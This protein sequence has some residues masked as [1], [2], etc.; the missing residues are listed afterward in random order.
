MIIVQLILS[1]S[2]FVTGT[3][4][5]QTVPG[6]VNKEIIL[7]LINEARKNGCTCG[8]T[9]YPPAAPLKWNDQL[10][11]AA[12]S[13]SNDMSKKNYFS[14][15][16]PSGTDAGSR[17]EKA[18]YAWT[19]YAENIGMGYR[20]EQEVVDAWLH[21]PGHCK[22]IM[23]Q[24]YKEIGAGRSGDYWTLDFGRPLSR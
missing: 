11:E 22:N 12:Y 9:Y 10:E 7:K 17:M 6:T 5:A 1:V 18:G 14:H 15:I 16:E 21:S 4:G 8:G 13:H 2:L 24:A 3:K 19:N 23:G 20:T